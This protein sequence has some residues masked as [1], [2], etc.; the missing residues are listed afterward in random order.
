[1]ADKYR[2]LFDN[3]RASEKLKTEVRN[4]TKQTRNEGKRRKIPIWTMTS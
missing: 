2:E 1:M 3:V 4:M